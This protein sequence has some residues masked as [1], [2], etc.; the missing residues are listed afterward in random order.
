MPII[1]NSVETNRVNNEVLTVIGSD[2]RRYMLH[3]IPWRVEGG[4]GSTDRLQEVIINYI[5]YGTCKSLQMATLP[6]LL[7]HALYRCALSGW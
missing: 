5:D 6:C 1:V 2:V 3:Y 4:F 7:R